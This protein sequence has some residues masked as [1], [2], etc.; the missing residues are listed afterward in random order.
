MPP[1]PP[2]VKGKKALP[3]APLK[4]RGKKALPSAPLVDPPTSTRRTRRTIPS[5][6][7]HLGVRDW[8]TDKNTL[9][10]LN[11]ELCHMEIDEPCAWTVAVLYLK[12]LD[13]PSACG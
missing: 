3:S 1:P 6:T 11:Q 7:T 5:E 10:W 4:V 9:C 13:C 12:R 2:K 8:L